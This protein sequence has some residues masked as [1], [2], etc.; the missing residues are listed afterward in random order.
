MSHK[1]GAY[2]PDLAIAIATQQAAC[3]GYI[4]DGIIVQTQPLGGAIEKQQPRAQRNE[5]KENGKKYPAGGQKAIHAS[6]MASW[7]R[8]SVPWI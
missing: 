2:K 4:R 8:E 3:P 7:Q 1:T 6:V 5:R